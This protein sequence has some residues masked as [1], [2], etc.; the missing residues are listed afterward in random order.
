MPGNRPF[1]FPCPFERET[2]TRAEKL[3][4][5]AT[6]KSQ[7][8]VKDQVIWELLQEREAL[9][10]KQKH[11]EKQAKE[12]W[13]RTNAELEGW[14]RL[15]DNLTEELRR[16][17]LGPSAGEGVGAQASAQAEDED[18]RKGSG[19]RTTSLKSESDLELDT[20]AGARRPDTCTY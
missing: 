19:L 2:A 1:P 7:L 10:E 3:L 6:L 13:Q 8:A 20:D 4:E 17:K 18:E 15:V 11:T 9:L 14:Q 16:A 12:L 5:H